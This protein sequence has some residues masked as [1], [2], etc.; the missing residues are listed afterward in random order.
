MAVVWYDA[1]V[2]APCSDE[3]TDTWPA[4]V[5]TTKDTP[6]VR[7]VTSVCDDCLATDTKTRSLQ[8]YN[9]EL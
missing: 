9:L 6:A 1:V 4:D 3:I 8:I 7:H 5:T 2:S